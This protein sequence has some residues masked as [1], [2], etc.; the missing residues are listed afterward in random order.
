MCFRII[1]KAYQCSTALW[2]FVKIQRF[3]QAFAVFLANLGHLRGAMGPLVTVR[4]LSKQLDIK[5]SKIR[6][7]TKKGLLTPISKSKLDGKSYLYDIDCVRIKLEILDRIRIDFPSLTEI[8]DRFRQV[9]G[10]RDADLREALHTT[11]NPKG[12]VKKYI[13]EIRGS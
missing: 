9:F 4:E 12:L 2:N 6:R 11:D 10:T 7:W 3:S 5:E 13:Q 8:A 1:V